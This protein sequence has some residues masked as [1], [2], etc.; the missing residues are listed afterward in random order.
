MNLIM[1]IGLPFRKQASCA[2][3]LGTMVQFRKASGVKSIR[4]V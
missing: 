3:K 4:T 2:G 1:G